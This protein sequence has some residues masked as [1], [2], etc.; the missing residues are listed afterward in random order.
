MP[1][2][3]LAVPEKTFGLAL[4]L[5]FFDRCGKS[6]P[7]SSAA[8]SGGLLFPVRGEGMA[9]AEMAVCSCNSEFRI[10]NC[11]VRRVH[12]IPNSAFRIANS[13]ERTVGG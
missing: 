9:G 11:S 12:A 13:S 2:V 6:K 8:G 7:P 1:P 3:S 10:P 4:I 5:G